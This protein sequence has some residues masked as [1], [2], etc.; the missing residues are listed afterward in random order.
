MSLPPDCSFNIL[1]PMLPWS[2]ADAPPLL[3]IEFAPPMVIWA[4]GRALERLAIG[5]ESFAAAVLH[6]RR[7]FA[8]AREE[9]RGA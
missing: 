6:A 2:L 7:S 5:V 3:V 1:F 8:I 9:A 4:W